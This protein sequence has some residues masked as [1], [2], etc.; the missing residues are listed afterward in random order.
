M[1]VKELIDLLNHMPEDALVVI[2]S[3]SE[4]NE[5]SPITDAAEGFYLTESS[6][7][8]EFYRAD[9]LDDYDEPE[10]IEEKGQVSVCLYSIG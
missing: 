5:S 10:E 6:Q 4:G 8:G 2:S 1:K 7:S 9:H 3:D